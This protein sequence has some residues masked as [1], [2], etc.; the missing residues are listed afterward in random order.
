VTKKIALTLIAAA[1]FTACT[2][3]PDRFASA[4]PIVKGC[5]YV[6]GPEDRNGF[7]LEVAYKEYSFFPSPDPV[8]V[9]ARACFAKTATELA[10]RKGK[11]I[12]PLGPSDMST[13]SNRNTIDSTYLVHVAGRVSY[14]KP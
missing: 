9:A 12:G 2:T 4:D 11:A 7:A 14:A 8:I 10:L 5:G 6:I 1:T 13:T 3:I